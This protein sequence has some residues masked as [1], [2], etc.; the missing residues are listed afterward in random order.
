MDLYH[1]ADETNISKLEEESNDVQEFKAV[2]V[3]EVKWLMVT[4]EDENV[5]EDICED[6][7]S[8]KIH[9]KV[10]A[11]QEANITRIET[12]EVEEEAFEHDQWLD[13]TEGEARADIASKRIPLEDITVFEVVGNL[14]SSDEV[15]A[16]YETETQPTTE[17]VH[18]VASH[19]EKVSRDTEMKE[20]KTAEVQESCEDNKVVSMEIKVLRLTWEELLLAERHMESEKHAEAEIQP[21]NEQVHS[22]ESHDEKV[23]RDTEMKEMETAEVQESCEDNKVVSKEIKVLRITWEELLLAERHMDSEK[24]AEAEIQPNNE[25]VHS[26]ES[27]D[28]KVSRDTEMKEM[29]TA[30]VQES[31]EDNKEV[32]KEIKVLRLT[33]EE[34]LLAERHMESAVV[35]DLSSDQVKSTRLTLAQED[36]AIQAFKIISND[37]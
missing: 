22:G 19:A 28:E 23:S 3:E 29:E 4:D 1:F 35:E 12:K 16:E 37:R 2:I 10:T 20:M 33:W 31:C 30:E 13:V 9:V 32:T 24:H 11:I 26:G 7:T 5:K 8:P 21:N 17:Q 25:Q 36:P 6:I 27:H 15:D 34:L 14:Q 18:S